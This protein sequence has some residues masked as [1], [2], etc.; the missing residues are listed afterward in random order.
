[1]YYIREDVTFN[2]IE[3]IEKAEIKCTLS[4]GKEII[5]NIP[6]IINGSLVHKGDIIAQDS[7]AISLLVPDERANEYLQFNFPVL[8]NQEGVIYTVEGN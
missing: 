6:Y 3:G 5:V 4:N 2:R 7:P 1:M 8:C